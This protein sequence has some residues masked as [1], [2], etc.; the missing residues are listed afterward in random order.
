MPDDPSMTTVHNERSEDEI[1][2]RRMI[3]LFRIILVVLLTVVVALV[4]VRESEDSQLGIKPERWW[5]KAVAGAVVFLAIVISLDV[6]SPKRKLST[7][8]AVLFGSFAGLVATA[9]LS[10]VIDYLTEVYFKDADAELRGR[11]LLT[12]KLILALGLCYLGA[13][14]VLQTQDDFRLVIPYVEFAKQLRGPKPLLLDTSA[15]ID[16]R[17]LDVA[18]VGFVQVPII[19]PRF[20][21]AELQRLSDSSDKLKRARGRRG[22]DIITKLQKSSRLDVALDESLAVGSADVDQLLVELARLMPATI[23]T[24]D[25]GLS[26]VAGIQGVTVLN[27]NDLANAMKPSVI[28]GEPLSVLLIK[29]GEQRG[30]GVGYLDD[31]TMVVAEDGEASV[32]HDVTL[33]VTSTMQTSA[34]RLIFGR[35]QDAGAGSPGND[36]TPNPSTN[37][38]DAS[39]DHHSRQ[40]SGSGQPSGHRNPRRSS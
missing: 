39:P 3:T 10:I 17:F 29:R 38:A 24:T 9:L 11:V 26:R 37:P 40:P 32:G 2:R 12:V 5:W 28:P 34:G 14:T 33:T 1:Q 16:G 8:S 7:I 23:V 20:V 22:L 4:I 36:T 19:V 6:L 27:I 15:I 31:G 25:T 13:A 18:E 35:M 30:Q 21:V